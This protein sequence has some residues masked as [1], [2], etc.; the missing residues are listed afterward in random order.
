VLFRGGHAATAINA[1]ALACVRWLAAFSD[2][3]GA[4]QWRHLNVRAAGLIFHL[5]RSRR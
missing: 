1:L 5:N 4:D 3:R 2:A